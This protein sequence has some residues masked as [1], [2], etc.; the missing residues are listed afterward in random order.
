MW[1]H[2]N[3]SVNDVVVSFEKS[4]SENQYQLLC[5]I[6]C[7][8][9]IFRNHIPSKETFPALQ[10][11]MEKST[12]FGVNHKMN[13]YKKIDPVPIDYKAKHSEMQR[14]KSKLSTYNTRVFPDIEN[15]VRG[16]LCCKIVLMYL[17]T[18]LYH[19]NFI[20]NESKTS[21]FYS[22]PGQIREILSYIKRCINK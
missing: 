13:I 16:F 6:Y 22:K 10:S 8:F 17:N 5:F 9:L 4:I 7:I 21:A 11:L 14:L 18:V 2:I 3:N 20:S 15:L 12:Y 1:R 19:V